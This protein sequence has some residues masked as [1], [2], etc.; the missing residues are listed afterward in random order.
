MNEFDVEII[1]IILTLNDFDFVM[2]INF[3]K[4]Q[5]GPIYGFVNIIDFI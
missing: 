4:D 2:N 1:L 5:E 3:K